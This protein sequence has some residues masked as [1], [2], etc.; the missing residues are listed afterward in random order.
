MKNTQETHPAYQTENLDI[1]TPEELEANF[2][3]KPYTTY[4]VY[5]N[6]WIIS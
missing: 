5:G 6:G 3:M 4:S 2:A 1:T